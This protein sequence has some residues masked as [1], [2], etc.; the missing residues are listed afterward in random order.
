[1][2][3][4]LCL[5]RI[6][7]ESSVVASLRQGQFAKISTA[8]IPLDLAAIVSV[9]ATG[10]LNCLGQC[11]VYHMCVTVIWDEMQNTCKIY[12]VMLEQTADVGPSSLKGFVKR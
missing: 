2:Q 5:I 10:V 4:V 6:F 7:L 11:S 8:N 1:M 9:T 12:N 3:N